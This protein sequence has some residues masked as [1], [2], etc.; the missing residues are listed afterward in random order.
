MS[1]DKIATGMKLYPLKKITCPISNIIPY[2]TEKYNLLMPEKVLE[3][4]KVELN[5][6][7][8]VYYLKNCPFAQ[9]ISTIQD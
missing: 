7:C 5:L 1:I 6:K 2:D 3:K 4:A 9:S 8:Y